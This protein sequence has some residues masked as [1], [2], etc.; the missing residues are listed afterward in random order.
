M[1]QTFRVF[2]VT[3]GCGAVVVAYVFVIF[4]FVCLLCPALPPQRF[5]K[6]RYTRL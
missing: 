5:P 3:D 1:T 6:E 4:L 2:K